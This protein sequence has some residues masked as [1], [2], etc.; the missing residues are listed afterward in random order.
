[1]KQIFAA[2]LLALALTACAHPGSGQQPPS[3][4]VVNCPAATL[5][6]TAYT[7]VNAP[8]S[9]SVPA[10]IT[11]ASYDWLPPSVGAWCATVQAW[12]QPNG[13]PPYQ[14]SAPSNVVQVTTTASLTHVELT[15]TPPATT[16]VYA[17]YTYI[18]SYAPATAVAVPTAP[19]LSP[20]TTQTS[21]LEQ[22]A[23]T[24]K[25]PAPIGLQAVLVR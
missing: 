18:V 24:K 7:E 3:P 15:W 25:L 12:A 9:T 13:A 2:A 1:M 22:T 17:S 20:A 23:P 10:N 16:S 8:A 14:V 19:P 6:G 21:M 5:G 4:P 11:A